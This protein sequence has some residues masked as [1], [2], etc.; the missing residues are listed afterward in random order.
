MVVETFVSTTKGYKRFAKGF[1][2]G[3]KAVIIV[4]VAL[5]VAA[6]FAL[7][8]LTSQPTYG[9]LF[10]NLSASDAGAITAKLSSAGVPYQLTNSGSV[11]EVPENMVYQER[12]LMAEAGLPAT[13][14]V[15]LSL[16]SNVSVA[17]PQ[18]AQQASYQAALQGQ[19]AQ[20]IEA[21]NGVQNAQINL[22]LPPASSTAGNNQTPTA[23]VIVTLANGVQLSSTQ[24]QGI[25][26]LV[27]SAIPGMNANGVTVVDQN[28]AV[29]ASPAQGTTGVGALSSTQSYDVKLEASI[30][31]MLTSI[32]G[33]NQANVRVAATLDLNKLNQSSQQIATIKGKPQ[34]ALTHS[35]TQT[36]TYTGTGVVT[37]GGTLGAIAPPA[38]A[39]TNSAYNQKSANN[40]YAVGQ[41]DQTVVQPPGQ[42]QR[43]SVAVV[44]NSKAKPTYSLAKIKTLVAAAAGIVPKRGDTLSVT[45]LPFATQP[46]TVAVSQSSLGS[47]LSIA[48]IA[49]LV[50]G[51]L[52]AI[53]VMTRSSRKAE[54]EALAVNP[55]Q[56]PI[57]IEASRPGTRAVAMR[58]AQP[59]VGDDVLD[60]IKQQPDDVAGLLRL[61][62]G[63]Q[64]RT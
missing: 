58:P 36:Q 11:I 51:V 13:S 7:S 46:K 33:P 2:I 56:A 38:G 47:I 53:F 50:L 23:S 19:L 8:A 61:W 49:A 24:I 14:T 52:V 3:Q 34:S 12:N 18:I 6:V 63:K 25:V 57:A 29:L 41:V 43:L 44:I 15:G 9:V 37:P 45:S 40:S 32:L 10:T 5:V 42:L 1:S 39:G 60:Y 4:G 27:S 30:E 31:S 17:T 21:I 55:T 20:T 28:G 64:N 62:L 26:H 35:Q 16:L 59:V 54:V 48:K 22:A